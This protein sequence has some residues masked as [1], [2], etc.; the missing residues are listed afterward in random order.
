MRKLVDRSHFITSQPPFRVGQ[1]VKPSAD[2]IVANLFPREKAKRIG[3]VTKVD[4]FNCPTVLWQ[5]RKTATG[6]HPRFIAALRARAH[7]KEG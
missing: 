3:V 1:K 4:Q 6:Y 2:G 7:K 5:G